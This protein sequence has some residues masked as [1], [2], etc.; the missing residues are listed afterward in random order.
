MM[1]LNRITNEQVDESRLMHFSLPVLRAGP[2]IPLKPTDEMANPVAVA[3]ESVDSASWPWELLD[4]CR[5]EFGGEVQPVLVPKDAILIALNQA[6]DMASASA[7]QMLENLEDDDLGLAKELEE[8]GD[9]LE[10]E[11]DAPVIRLVNTLLSQALK[12][13]ASDIH[14]E[15]FESQVLVRF[16][17]DG[18]LH[19]IVKPPKAVQAAM[20]SRIKVMA[21]LDISEKRHPQDGRFRVKVAGR[22][23]DVRVSVLPTAHGERVV[24]RLL[25]RSAQL[26]TLKDLGMSHDQHSIM[27]GVISEPHGIVLVT[28]PTGSGKST[29]LYAALMEVDRKNRNVM[30]IEDPIEYQLEGVGQ[31]QVR[32][33]I[34]VTFA[35]GLRSILRQD[36]DIVMIGEIRDLETAEIAIQASLTGHMVFATLHTNDALSAIVRLQDMGVEPYLVASSLVMA[37][38][39]RLVRRLCEEC[40]TPREVQ[41][42]EWEKLDVKSEKMIDTT[43]V[44]DAHGCEHCLNTG[45]VGRVAIYE[46][47][48]I[49]QAI[50]NAIHDGKGLPALRRLAAKEG[51]ISLRQDGA[52]H[53]AAGM[54]TFDEVL[55]ATRAD[56]V[57]DVA[58]EVAI[59]P[60]TTA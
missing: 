37:Q 31:M 33:K 55:M 29:T 30:T 10:S 32:P 23:V 58:P 38:A 42:A 36:P 53:I 57:I 60:V 13:R 48:P 54:T 27:S 50:R 6:F 3:A 40:K 39:Q 41:L 20:V 24:M 18:V 22:E 14:I 19:S 17:I 45:Y 35:A 4:D 59:N 9:L 49:T 25:D 12:D 56:V 7:E 47:M 16:R 2:V 15:P 28:G 52:R 8:V 46:L 51:A 21:G 11:D 1:H 34:G 5:R 26:L 44:Y 43:V